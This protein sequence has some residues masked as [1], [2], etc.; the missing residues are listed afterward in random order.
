MP[1]AQ[2]AAGAPIYS[3]A[4]DP[5][6]QM[7]LN[8]IEWDALADRACGMQ[9]EAVCRAKAETFRFCATLIRNRANDADRRAIARKRNGG[10]P[11]DLDKTLAK[12]LPVEEVVRITRLSKSSVYRLVGDGLLKKLSTGLNTILITTESVRDLYRNA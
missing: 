7:E 9:I 10:Q 5:V 8:A 11:L 4:L 1:T 3:K 2:T 6:P 12:S